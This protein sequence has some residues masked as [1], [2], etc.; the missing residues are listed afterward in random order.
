MGKRANTVAPRIGIT[1]QAK[2]IPRKSN[3]PPIADNPGRVVLN[4]RI[5][6]VGAG[7]F[8][9]RVVKE[10]TFVDLASLGGEITLVDVRNVM[11]MNE[12]LFDVRNETGI[13]FDYYDITDPDQRRK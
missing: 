6:W 3:P 4:P 2:S 7:D 11:E 1:K 13:D 5:L 12:R 10:G 9:N 8:F